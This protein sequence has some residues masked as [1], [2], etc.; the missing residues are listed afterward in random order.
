MNRNRPITGSLVLLDAN[1]LYPINVCDFILT[2]SSHQLL[3]TK[4]HPTPPLIDP[5]SALRRDRV[6]LRDRQVCTGQRPGGASFLQAIEVG[7]SIRF[8]V[9]Q[10]ERFVAERAA[11]AQGSNTSSP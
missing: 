1:V 4:Q 3:A 7:R 6:Q 5:T 8:T 10:L 9:D 2:A 11:D